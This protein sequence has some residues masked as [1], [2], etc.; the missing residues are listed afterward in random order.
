MFTRYV[1]VNDHNGLSPAARLLGTERKLDTAHRCGVREKSIN[2]DSRVMVTAVFIC[3]L[4]H[5]GAA[6]LRLL[7]VALVSAHRLS[8]R[9]L[10]KVK[11]LGMS[12]ERGEPFPEP[13]LDFVSS[14]VPPAKGRAA[15]K[16]AGT[17]FGANVF[18]TI[19]V[20]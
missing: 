20:I 18:R 5:V 19:A 14:T 16:P 12:T 8:E 1:L 7:P 10:G 3:G 2:R 13:S 4:F 9:E 11:P 6:R 15:R 17:V